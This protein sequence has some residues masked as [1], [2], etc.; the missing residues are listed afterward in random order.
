MSSLELRAGHRAR[1]SVQLL[2]PAQ[3][4]MMQAAGQ[5]VPSQPTASGGQG[6]GE[7]CCRCSC[8]ASC[9]E[10]V[11]ALKRVLSAGAAPAALLS[12]RVDETRANWLRAHRAGLQAEPFR[13]LAGA[14]LY[15]R[16]PLRV[17]IAPFELSLAHSV[18]PPGSYV[19]RSIC[20]QSSQAMNAAAVQVPRPPGRGA[21]AGGLRERCAPA[22]QQS[23]QGDALRL[24]HAGQQAAGQHPWGC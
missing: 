18:L 16:Q 7:S 17:H 8:A 2:P 22:G 20:K 15:V 12:S 23:R 10:Q 3:A 6:A 9:C 5:A 19:R 13:M 14:V 11:M 1:L 21:W 4:A 24:Q